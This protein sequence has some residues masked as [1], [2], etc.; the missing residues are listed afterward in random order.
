[1]SDA[2]WLTRWIVGVGIAGSIAA[3]LVAVV[4][5]LGLLAYI[6]LPVTIL[7]ALNAPPYRS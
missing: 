6:L 3:A 7:A 4:G 5:P 2:E 1:M